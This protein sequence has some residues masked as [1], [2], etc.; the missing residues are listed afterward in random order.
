[1]KIIKVQLLVGAVVVFS[2]MLFGN[3]AFA[4]NHEG[5]TFA[6]VE[7][8][9]CNFLKGKSMDDLDKV[10]T[11]WNAWMDEN[12]NNN[13]SAVTF[14]PQFNDPELAFDVG[15]LGAWPDGKAMGEGMHEQL[16]EGKDV[17]AEFYQV[18][19]CGVHAGFAAVTINAPSAPPG[20]T[21]V[22]V[23]SDCSMAEGKKPADSSSALRAWAEYLQG[24]GIDGP[25]WTLWPAYGGGDTDYDF[26]LVTAHKDYQAFG[27][28][29]DQI[30]NGGGYRKAAE[31]FDGVVDCD[32][33]RVYDTRLRRSMVPPK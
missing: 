2:A 23:F 3:A 9:A 16:N 10:T 22:L 18:V 17:I 27:A 30:T 25:I 24:N 6:P 19:E 13:Y 32:T 20:E 8:Y 33:A 21:G 1:M 7:I 29:F 5:P 28:A 4:D 26:K 12:D 14:T 15:W 11:K 31:I